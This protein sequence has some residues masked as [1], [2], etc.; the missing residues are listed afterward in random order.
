MNAS[1]PDVLD[2]TLRNPLLNFRPSRRRGFEVVDEL[3]REIFR[4]LVGGERVMYFLT[5]PEDQASPAPQ[6]PDAAPSDVP[7]ELLALLSQPAADPNG[8]AARR[9]S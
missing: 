6:P 5:A 8:A 1:H 3:S 2:L 4:I 7:A 9:W